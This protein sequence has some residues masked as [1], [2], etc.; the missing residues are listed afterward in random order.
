MS[1]GHSDNAETTPEARLIAAIREPGGILARLERSAVARQER[2]AL[3]GNKN[4]RF[5]RLSYRE[6]F[7]LVAKVAAGLH[8]LGLRRGD[9]IGLIAENSDL[10]LISDLACQSLGAVDVPRGADASAEEVEFCVGH[11]ECVAAIVETGDLVPKLRSARQNLR[12]VVV[13]R[14]EAPPGTITIDAVIAQGEAT[15]AQDPN[16]LAR[17]RAAINPD[18]LATIIYTSGTTGNPK[19]VMLSHAN[20]LQN[21]AIVPEVLH[22][23]EGGKFLSFLPAWHSFERVLD[24]VV[25]D[26]GMEIHYSSKWTLREDFQRVRPEFVAGV[27]RLWE[28]FHGTVMSGIEKLSRGKRRLVDFALSSSQRH[29]QITRLVRG[30][31]LDPQ[32]GY[33]RPGPIS[34]LGLSLERAA[35]WPGHWLAQKLV[36]TKL[37]KALGGSTRVIISGGGPLPAHVDEFYVQAGLPFLN[38]YGMT[39]S[40]PVISVRVPERNILGTI[41]PPI[42]LT[43][44]RIVDEQGKILGRGQRGVIQA[45]GHQV[46][47]GYFRNPTATKAALPGDGWLDTGD[48]GMLS[49]RGDLIITGRAKDT[50]VLRGGENVEPEPLEATLTASPWIAEAVL[51]GHGEK[52]LAALLV[53]NTTNLREKFGLPNSVKEAEMAADPRIVQLLKDEVAARIAKKR[54]HRNFE[55]VGRVHVLDRPFTIEEGTLTATMKKRR[56]AIE[57]RY[58]ELIQGLF[59][60]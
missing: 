38:G 59:S 7:D 2:T 33:K 58:A 47:Q 1:P 48:I 16:L 24:Y 3:V 43:E 23:A 51:V 13:L 18:D 20:L 41:G 28:T 19:G 52:T 21:V 4:C 50:I 8:A 17:S 15:L 14:G 10:W 25:L 37:K 11:A 35:H 49:E 6:M 22:L 54:G 31:S 46:M 45:R 27:P 53:P 60:D 26:S 44:V 5:P 36:Y 39:E 29:A 34:K 42:P 55:L 9:H 40:S 30:E 12:Q 57:A 32:G 56:G